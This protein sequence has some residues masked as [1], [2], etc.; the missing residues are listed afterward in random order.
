MN[1]KDFVKEYSIKSF[2]C[3]ISG[4]KDSLVMTHYCLSELE[5]IDVDKYVV[6]ADTGCMLPC[7]TPFLKDVSQRF[8]WNLIIVYGN[9]FEHV[10]KKGMPSMFRRWCCGVCKLN[11]IHEFVKTLR[12][13]RAEATG[14]R[15][16]ESQRRKK[17]RLCEV[18]F[19]KKSWV[20]KYAP[21][22]SWSEKDVLRYMKENDLPMPPH[23]KL[24]L[25]ETC[26]CGAFSSKRQMMIL[27]ANYPEMFQK[28]VNVEKTFKKGGACFYFNNK[29]TYAKD[30][31]KQKTVDAWK[32]KEKRGEG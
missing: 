8:G 15:S 6:H 26:Q 4:G 11:P 25:K 29:P 10:Q 18:F 3:S 28:F 27:K 19:L 5:G 17:M 13:Q 30:L 20:W 1:P 31:A 14:L 22:L 12:P 7:V 24:G 16:D 23:Y 32:E 9:F 21:I 2:V